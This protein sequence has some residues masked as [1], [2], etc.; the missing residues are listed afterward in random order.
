MVPWITRARLFTAL[1]VAAIAAGAACWLLLGPA[2]AVLGVVAGPVLVQL[3][4]T[5][6]LALTRPDPAELLRDHEPYRALTQLEPELRNWRVLA[7]RHPAMFSDA[8][9]FGLLVQAEA[10]L[11]LGRL[12][13]APRPAAEAVGIFRALAAGKPRR[14]TARL[15]EALGRQARVL[16]GV[17]SEPEALRSAR[18]A[19][20]LYRNLAAPAPARFLPP[21]AGLLTDQAEWLSDMEQDAEALRAADEAVAICQDRLPLDKQP[22]CAAQALLLQGRLRAG[23]ARYREAAAPLARGWQLAA[24]REQADLLAPA[25]ASLR[26]AYQADEAAVRSAW[27]TETGGEPPEWLTGTQQPPS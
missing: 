18:E 27:R 21:L 4:L 22:P 25:V 17:G 3:T 24:S 10:L 1:A 26:A 2:W 7:R 12:A 5:A 16:A 8:L 23:Q 20:Q 9:G 13:E 15:A 6:L 14:F 11:A 19:A